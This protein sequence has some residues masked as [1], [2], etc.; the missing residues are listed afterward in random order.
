MENQHVT[1]VYNVP[2]GK[3]EMESKH[4]ARS[5]VYLAL[6]TKFTKKKKNDAFSNKAKIVL[7]APG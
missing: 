3:K 5:T 4:L 2:T 6:H 1:V 7:E